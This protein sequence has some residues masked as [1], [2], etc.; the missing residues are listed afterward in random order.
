MV[1]VAFD[2]KESTTTSHP[3]MLTIT[4]IAIGPTGATGPTGPTGATGAAGAQGPVGPTGAQGPA[5]ATGAQGPQGAV[6]AQG[7]QGPVGSTG[8]IGPAGAFNVYDA[9]NQLL[10]TAL[11]ANGS[12]FIPSLGLIVEFVA[13]PGSCDKTAQTCSTTVYQP[14]SILLDYSNQNCTGT[15]YAPLQPWG[16]Q[17]LLL[18]N[19]TDRSSLATLQYGAQPAYDTT[20]GSHSGYDLTG[21]FECINSAVTLLG[22]GYRIV[23]VQPFTGTLPFTLPAV[24]PLRLA[25]AN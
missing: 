18:T 21:A 11:D 19:Q 9:N 10:G 22:P 2:S 3:A 20:A 17:Q 8:L 23:T 7:P 12:V 5:G 25:Q 13:S 15:V 4:L 16:S 24:P 14:T 1:L 6:G